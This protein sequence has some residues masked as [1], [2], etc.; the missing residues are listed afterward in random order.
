MN[1][2]STTIAL[3]LL[4]TTA[5][6]SGN[7]IAHKPRST[8]NLLDTGYQAAGFQGR[9][10]G[11]IIGKSFEECQHACVGEAWCNYVW[12]KDV[13][14]Y[15]SDKSLTPYTDCYLLEDD[16]AVIEIDH[17]NGGAVG[18]FYK[19]FERCPATC[20]EAF[21][22]GCPNGKRPWAGRETHTSTD[23]HYCCEVPPPT[24]QE[25]FASGC[26]NG[27]TLIPG[28]ESHESSDIDY[29]CE[30]LSCNAIGNK[31]ACKRTT[32]CKYFKKRGAGECKADIGCGAITDKRTCKTTTGCKYSRKKSKCRYA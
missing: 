1:T 18:D 13:P 32:G 9:F 16:E 17:N 15:T 19:I 2:F 25:A 20:Q 7:C 10:S 5:L 14:T 4:G 29:C 30:S 27:R 3:G 24:C 22:N 21:P 11:P 26:P 28:R 12:M 23:E 6:A 31:R 8:A